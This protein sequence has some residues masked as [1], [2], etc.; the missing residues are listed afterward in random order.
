MPVLGPLRQNWYR[1]KDVESGCSWASPRAK[2]GSLDLR[3]IRRLVSKCKVWNSSTSL[4][5]RAMDCAGE[6]K[7]ISPVQGKFV[8]K[9][10]LQC[11][12]PHPLLTGHLS[13]I[14]RFSMG[15][16]SMFESQNG[17]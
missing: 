12:S 8:T 5:C 10:D 11:S 17:F 3:S 4:I 16:N 9:Y 14:Y 13:I 6:V 7:G 1:S 2:I 15:R